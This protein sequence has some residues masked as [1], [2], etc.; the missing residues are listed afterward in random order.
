MARWFITATFDDQYHKHFRWNFGG[1]TTVW[2]FICGT[3]RPKY[4]SD[5]DQIKARARGA[6]E[7]TPATASSD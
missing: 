7:G 5:F 1:N 3:V 4:L 2:N 6:P